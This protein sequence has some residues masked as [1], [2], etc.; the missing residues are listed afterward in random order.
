MPSWLKNTLI[1][2]G[3]LCGVLFF[4]LH[5]S[6]PITSIAQSTSNNAAANGLS[7]F[8]KSIRNQV[9]DTKE[10]DKYILPLDK[11]D[12]T[13]E[14]AL[15]MRTRSVDPMSK[16]WSGEVGTRRFEKGSTLKKALS[17][18]AEKEGIILYWYLDKDFVVKENFR[19]DSDFTSA[20]YQVSRTIN[21]DFENEVYVFFCAKQRAAIITE[22]PSEFIRST[23]TK[24]EI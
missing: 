3:L 12:I 14:R 5:E 11:P 16:F 17:A 23:C 19:I 24:S 20:L 10:R 2:G 4:V 22:L 18:Q 8:Y 9:N 21:N 7:R 6:S 13:A 15:R 1:L